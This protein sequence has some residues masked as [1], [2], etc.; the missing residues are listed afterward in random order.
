MYVL[1]G[2]GQHVETA[3]IVLYGKTG[4]YLYLLLYV[5][6]V[7]FA[8]LPAFY[9]HRNNDHYYSL[10]ASGAVAS[11]IFCFIM[12]APDAGLYLMFI[13]IPIPAYIFGVGY[14]ALE[15]YLD[16]RGQGR[17]AHD[18]HFFGAVFGIIFI[19]ILD[20]RYLTNFLSHF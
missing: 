20:Y 12:M 15:Y 8:T 17:V 7:V 6:G 5:G 2:F 16:K 4:M 18:A 13:P 10:G 11:V 1:Y 3:F 14:L 9:R 19:T